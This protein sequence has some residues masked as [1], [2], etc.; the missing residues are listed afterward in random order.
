MEVGRCPGWSVP[1]NNA[2]TLWLTTDGLYTRRSLRAVRCEPEDRL[3]MAGPSTGGSARVEGSQ[4]RA[5][6]LSASYQD[7]VEQLL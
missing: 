5:P 7:G 3:Q 6:P 4:P 2:Y 1:C